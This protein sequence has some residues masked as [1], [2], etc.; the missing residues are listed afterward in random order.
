MFQTPHVL[1]MGS[2][3]FYGPTTSYKFDDDDGDG[4]APFVG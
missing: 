2:R 1:S 3:R 4:D